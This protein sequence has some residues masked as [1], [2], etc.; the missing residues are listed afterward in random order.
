MVILAGGLSVKTLVI[1]AGAV[2]LIYGICMGGG[3]KGNSKDN[4]KYY[5]KKEENPY[6]HAG[7][8]ASDDYAPKGSGRYKDKDGKTHRE[9]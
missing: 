1:I 7:K 6:V 4:G 2:I 9:K 3:K 8:L 5:D